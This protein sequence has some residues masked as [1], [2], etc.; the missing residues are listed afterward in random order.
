MHG[1]VA[2]ET[3]WGVLIAGSG[4]LSVDALAEFLYFI[5]MA[6]RA[7]GRGQLSCGS[8]LMMISVAGLAG[9]GAERS[10]DAGRHV[11]SLV[12]V[13]RRALNSCDLGGVW[14]LLDGGV[15]IG[16]GQNAVDAGRMLHGVD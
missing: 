16:A 5:G 14:I 10:V 13:A 9:G 6:L 1:L 8:H 11:G 12:G 15:T 3:G 7:L 4:R 2:G